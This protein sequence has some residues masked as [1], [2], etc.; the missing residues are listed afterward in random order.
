MNKSENSENNGIGDL[1]PHLK[2][3]TYSGNATDAEFAKIQLETAGKVTDLRKLAESEMHVILYKRKHIESFGGPPKREDIPM[4]DVRYQ[5]WTLL[6]TMLGQ[7]QEIALLGVGSEC[8]RDAMANANATIMGI[9]SAMSQSMESVAQAT[10][11]F[12]SYHPEEAPNADIPE[13]THLNDGAAQKTKKKQK[14]KKRP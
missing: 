10:E 5:Y 14:T 8:L 13:D 1:G 9:Q 3:L 11:A 7:V 4:L 2:S 12:E 6:D